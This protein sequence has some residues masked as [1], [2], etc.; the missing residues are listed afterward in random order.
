MAKD[1]SRQPWIF[2]AADQSYVP[3]ATSNR[4]PV[5]ST[6]SGQKPWIRQIKLDTGDGGDFLINDADGGNRLLKLDNTPANDTLWVPIG[7]SWKGLFVQTLA[8]NAS[9]E[10]YH[11]ES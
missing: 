3:D 1:T 5:Q 7:A 11:G 2:D 9:L 8:T 10:V 6:S 4:G